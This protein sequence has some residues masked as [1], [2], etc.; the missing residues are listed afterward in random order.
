MQGSFSLSKNTVSILHPFWKKKTTTKQN[1][2]RCLENHHVFHV[3]LLVKH[4]NFQY[5]ETLSDCVQEYS[6]KAT[7]AKYK[8]DADVVKIS[9]QRK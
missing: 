4:L 1:I 8:Y 9:G 3:N 5:G 6:K 2:S 7:R